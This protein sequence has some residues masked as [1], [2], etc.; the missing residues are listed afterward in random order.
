MKFQS[1]MT[2]FALAA[3]DPVSSFYKAL[4]RWC[5]GVLDAQTLRLLDAVDRRS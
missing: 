1:S 4:D 2:L 5:G 3:A